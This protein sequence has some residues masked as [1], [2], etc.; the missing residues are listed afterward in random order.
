[1]ITLSKPKV[2]KSELLSAL[3]RVAGKGQNDDRRP[4]GSMA[5]LSTCF[6]LEVN[7]AQM[8]CFAKVEQLKCSL[9]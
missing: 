4:T 3:G 1:M 7:K 8:L 5:G 9:P 2:K 6:A